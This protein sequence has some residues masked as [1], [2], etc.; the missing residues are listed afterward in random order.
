[1]KKFIFLWEVRRQDRQ[2]G[3]KDWKRMVWE[4]GR[5]KKGDVA[6]MDPGTIVNSLS[7]ESSCF[8]LT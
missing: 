3:G 1:M 7:Q 8:Q 6:F 2:K 4:K 5:E